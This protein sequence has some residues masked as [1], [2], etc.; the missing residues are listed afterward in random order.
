MTFNDIFIGQTAECFHNVTHDDIAKFVELSGDNNKLHVDFNYANKTEFKRPVAHGMLGA[1]FISSIIGTKLPGDGAL[2]FASQIE[3]LL[4]TYI[5]DELKIVA[6]VIHKDER[7]Q[8]IELRTSIF[9]QHRQLV[10]NGTAKVKIV[11]QQIDLAPL[12]KESSNGL[13]LILGGTGL[14]GTEAC[15]ALANDGHKIAIQYHSNRNQASKVT[16][17][18]TSLLPDDSQIPLTWQCDIT[19]KIQVSSMI[20]SIIQR[21]GPINTVVNCIAPKIIRHPLDKVTWADFQDN[22]NNQILGAFNVVQAVTPSMIENKKGK[23]IFVNS[24]AFDAPALNYIP[25][26][27]AKGALTGLMRSLAH[28]LGPKGIQVNAVSPGYTASENST[29][30]LNKREE[31][32]LLSKIPLRRVCSPKDVANAICYLASEKSNYLSGETIRLNGG[33]IMI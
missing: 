32:L 26:I 23:I 25:Y 15:I 5:G 6:Q 33:G 21:F 2:W 16:K 30:G 27:T 10:T 22:F 3:F 20:E 31:L 1:S 17:E 14:I 18:I 9:N 24:L 8:T 29:G 4:P 7:N 12:A 19:N 13:T 28:D 11:S